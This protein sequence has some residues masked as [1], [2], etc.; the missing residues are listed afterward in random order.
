MIDDLTITLIN[1]CTLNL[2]GVKDIDINH[3]A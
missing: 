3:I 1:L 2:Y